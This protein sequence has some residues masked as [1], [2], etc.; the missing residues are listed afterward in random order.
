[1][2][3]WLSPESDACGVS[4]TQPRVFTG[5]VSLCLQE[6]WPSCRLDLMTC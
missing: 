4:E 5:A 6:A 3:L 2:A 1:M